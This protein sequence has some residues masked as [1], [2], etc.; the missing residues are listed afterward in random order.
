MSQLVLPEEIPQEVPEPTRVR[1][2]K[3]VHDRLNP[4]GMALAA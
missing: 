4:E 1:G 3:K 2:T